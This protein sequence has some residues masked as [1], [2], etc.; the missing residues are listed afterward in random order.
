MYKSAYMVQI[1]R[2]KKAIKEDKETNVHYIQLLNMEQ[3]RRDE[4]ILQSDENNPQP[5]R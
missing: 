4:T 5:I 3:S 1:M 2:S